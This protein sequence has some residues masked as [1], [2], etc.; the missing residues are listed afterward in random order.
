M[1]VYYDE[2]QWIRSLSREYSVLGRECTLESIPVTTHDIHNIDSQIHNLINVNF[3][4]LFQT[5][6]VSEVHFTCL[7]LIK[8]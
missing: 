1:H 4:I 7:G 8:V 5:T 2:L 6:V 3:G